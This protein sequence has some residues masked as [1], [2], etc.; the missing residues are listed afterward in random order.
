MRGRKF[1]ILLALGVILVFTLAI[2]GT[3]LAAVAPDGSVNWSSTDVDTATSLSF[4]HTLG[5]GTDRLTLVALT[6]NTNTSPQDVDEV[7]FTPTSGSPIVL[8]EEV[9]ATGTRTDATDP[10]CSI[11]YSLMPDDEMLASGATGTIEVTFTG[12]IASGIVAGAIN[13]E[14]VDQTTPFEDKQAANGNG[15]VSTVTLTGLDGDELVLASNF[16]GASADT[17]VSA[18]NGQAELWQDFVV[19]TIG[20]AGWLMADASSET[21]GWTCAD[22]TD[23]YV[24]AIAAVAIN[25]ATTPVGDRWN[26]ISDQA[27]IDTYGVTAAQIDVVADGYPDGSFRPSNPVNRGQFAKMAVDGL[28][29]P[30]LN[31]LPTTPTFVDVGTSNT[32]FPWIETAWDAGIVSGYADG[33]YHPE[34]PMLRQQVATI[35]GR[36]QEMLEL[37]A[38]GVIHGSSGDYV[39]VEAWFAAE[40]AAVL[41]PFTDVNSV[42]DVH[43]PYVAFMIARGVMMGTSATTIGPLNTVTRAQAAVL[44]VRLTELP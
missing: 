3:A 29:I 14:G 25:P 4:S 20:A 33:H 7:T 6:Y 11:I 38:D 26:D 43:K 10:R 12:A 23:T 24:W 27:W 18:D 8:T 17:T 9:R 40:G 37:D 2:G 19:N 34:F 36:Y 35:L 31:P 42:A 22:Q 16:Q 41:A 30:V 28:G 21:I 5:T 13:F 39:D 15:W 44:I 1:S 32:F